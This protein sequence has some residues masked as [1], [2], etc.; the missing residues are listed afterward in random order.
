MNKI[1]IIYNQMICSLFYLFTGKKRYFAIFADDP[2][3]H[4]KKWIVYIVGPEGHSWCAIFQCPCGC[5]ESIH[6][7]LLPQGHPKWSHIVHR[8]SSVS[9]QP[10]IW[11]KKGCK[12]HFFLKRGMVKSC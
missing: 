3:K 4:L 6:L 12:S 5:K 7:N 11:R 10:S 9:F 8:N 1:A 2:P